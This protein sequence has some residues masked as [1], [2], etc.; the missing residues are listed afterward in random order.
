MIS[1]YVLPLLICLIF[2]VACIKK[3][4]IYAS[5]IR[6]VK[7]G[8]YLFID[9]YPSLLAM[10]FAIS[11]LSESGLMSTISSILSNVLPI[12]PSE[13][14]PMC[15]FRSFSGSTTLVILNTIYE[16]CGVDSF[17]AIMASIIEGS[18]DTTFYVISLYFSYIK[19]KDISNSLVIGLFADGIGIICAILLT[20][21][22]F[23]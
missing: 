11:L 20:Y 16:T 8:L 6:G 4:D 22:F 15:L 14:I 12:I 17:E 23:S 9:I 18:T 7:D 2:L 21:A 3:V 1:S 13:V 5:F 19:I 10:T